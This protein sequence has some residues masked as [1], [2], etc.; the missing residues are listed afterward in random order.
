MT[1][2]HPKPVLGNLRYRIVTV[3]IAILLVGCMGGAKSNIEWVWIW[4]EF[5]W[6]TMLWQIVQWSF[7]GGFIGFGLGVGLVFLLRR[8]RLYNYP[9]T[10]GKWIA[11]IICA[12]IIISVTLLTGVGGC[13][14]G[15]FRGSEISLRESPI[16]REWLPKAGAYGADLFFLV[17]QSL[18][19]RETP[20]EKLDVKAFV[21]QLDLLKEAVAEKLARQMIDQALEQNPGWKGTNC[22]A[23]IRWTLPWLARQLVDRKVKKSLEEW[24]VRGFMEELQNQATGM[25]EQ[26]MNRD[27]LG[28]FLSNRVIVPGILHFI[29]NWI[30]STQYVIAFLVIVAVGLPVA[31][32]RLLL[33]FKSRRHKGNI[34]DIG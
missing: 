29:R 21:G 12:W 9:G 16:G 6:L 19:Q 14:E 10:A 32:V 11:P 15:M 5:P 3:S 20:A 30:R 13:F 17:D 22:E 27:E 34:P 25:K 18:N 24:R 8:F 28:R 4:R 26:G 7:L 2:A 33:F 31:L 1:I 23:L